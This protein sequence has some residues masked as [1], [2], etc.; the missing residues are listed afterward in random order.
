MKNDKLYIKPIVQVV[1]TIPGIS[2]TFGH[3]KGAI[4]KWLKKDIPNISNKFL[5]EK[6]SIILTGA[7]Q[8]ESI[9]IMLE[10]GV[11]YLAIDFS[12][13]CRQTQ[14][15][16]W[17]TEIGFAALPDNQI[18]FGSRLTSYTRGLQAAPPTFSTPGIIRQVS[19]DFGLISDY[20]YPLDGRA[21]IITG[22]SQKASREVEMLVELLENKTRTLPVYVLT[23][24]TNNNDIRFSA[25]D[26]QALA[27]ATLGTAHVFYIDNTATYELR[28]IIGQELS[29]FNGAARTYNPGFDRFT[30]DLRA[31]PLTLPHT[32][33]RMGGSR[34]FMHFLIGQA[35]EKSTANR[36]R[37][38]AVLPRF[39]EI[40]SRHYETARLEEE[41]KHPD[42]GQKP[43]ADSDQS[44]PVLVNPVDSSSSQTT[45]AIVQTGDIA[46]DKIKINELEIENAKLKAL[47]EETK[48]NGE[49]ILS[50]QRAAHTQEL[51][52]MQAQVEEAL[53]LSAEEEYSRKIAEETV[54]RLQEQVDELLQRIDEKPPVSPALSKGLFPPLSLIGEWADATF[55]KERLIVSNRARKA[56]KDQVTHRDLTSIYRALSVLGGEYIDMRR[57]KNGASAGAKDIF[58]RRLADL[59]ME[60]RF[61]ISPDQANQYGDTYF[62]T[63]DGRRHFLRSHLTKG[64]ARD[65]QSVIR[66]YYAYDEEAGRVV[67]G[68]LPTHLINALT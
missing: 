50:A 27:R 21:V 65:P 20:R 2:E 1:G 57:A 29:V 23:A 11:N 67:V 52:A 32:I 49:R 35:Y 53:G 47:I 63:I 44:T 37:N 54:S 22:H 25:T 24:P 46:S 62:V 19:N 26:P 64:A 56:A 34:G 59:N 36:E 17:H 16:T 31:H 12:H 48:N 45:T 55:G 14:G 18:L 9:S 3:L 39:A 61:S 43:K 40:R 60:D 28:D 33:Q 15:R 41:K 6:R 5:D 58:D 30:Q 8:A 10:G 13:A 51:S 7:A 42:I 38:E 4:T 66:I 68:H